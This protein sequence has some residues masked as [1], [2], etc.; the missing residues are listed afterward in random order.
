MNEMDRVVE[1]EE[2]IAVQLTIEEALAIREYARQCGETVSDLIRKAVLRQATLA[3]GYGSDDAEYDY[4]YEL[5]T[6]KS[7]SQLQETKLVEQNCNH[8]RSILGWTKI[9]I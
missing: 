8:I 7:L 2:S 1:R 6:G 9:K 3:D 5:P 4:C